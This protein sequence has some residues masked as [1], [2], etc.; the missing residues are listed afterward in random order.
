M[1]VSR[2]SVAPTPSRHNPL[3]VRAGWHAARALHVPDHITLAVLPPC[4]TELSSATSGA[5]SQKTPKWSA[6]SPAEATQTGIKPGSLVSAGHAH[7][8]MLPRSGSALTRRQCSQTDPDRFR[9]GLQIL[10]PANS[11]GDASCSG[12]GNA[13]HAR[14]CRSWSAP[15][16][17]RAITRTASLADCLT[18]CFVHANERPAQG[19]CRARTFRQ[20]SVAGRSG[21]DK[22]RDLRRVA[23]CP[24]PDF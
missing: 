4:A 15:G 19:R 24:A 1:P 9:R 7:D 21:I 8:A 23:P 12:G 17:M 11:A 20:R 5:S 18:G 6:A 10:R 14:L 16:L 13:S 3:F 22:G 2:G